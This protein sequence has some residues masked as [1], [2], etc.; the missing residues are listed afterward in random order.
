[1]CECVCVYV[2]VC[3]CVCTRVRIRTPLQ[4]P[5]H[6][7]PTCP[8]PHTLHA[9]MHTMHATLNSVQREEQRETVRKSLCPSS[10]PVP[11]FTSRPTP[12]VHACSYPRGLTFKRRRP[13]DGPGLLRC[14]HFTLTTHRS[15]ACLRCCFLK[16]SLSFKFST[17]FC[18]GDLQFQCPPSSYKDGLRV[19]G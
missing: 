13:C 8:T 3:V 2:C 12:F 17:N 19:S 16:C 18:Y 5:M 9:A 11:A 14:P 7:A 1:M 6:L 10:Q 15:H 4:V